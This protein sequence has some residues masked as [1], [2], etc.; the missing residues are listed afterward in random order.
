M[1][2]LCTFINLTPTAGYS[3]TDAKNVEA[4]FGHMKFFTQKQEL[5]SDSQPDGT[6]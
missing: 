4:T 6:V 2:P 1:D 5:V 3:V